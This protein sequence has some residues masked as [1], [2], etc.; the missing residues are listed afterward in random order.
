MYCRTC[1]VE[2]VIELNAVGGVCSVEIYI[3]LYIAL[4]LCLREQRVKGLLLVVCRLVILGEEHAALKGLA[5]HLVLH[6]W[7]EE[8]V[9]MV[10]SYNISR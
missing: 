10:V 2:V 8:E 3:V 5:V 7:A 6:M 1:Y 4:L 9:P